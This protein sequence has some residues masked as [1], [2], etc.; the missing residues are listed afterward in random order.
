MGMAHQVLGDGD[1]ALICFETAIKI[2]P[3]YAAAYG[4]LGF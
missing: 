2:N 1:K 3:N 4:N